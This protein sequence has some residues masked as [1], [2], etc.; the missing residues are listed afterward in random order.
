[1]AGLN[2]SSSVGEKKEGGGGISDSSLIVISSIFFLVVIGWGGMR[3]YI[4]TQNDTLAKLDVSLE[5]SSSQLRGDKVNRVAYFDARSGLIGE[6][7]K[8]ESVDAKKLLTQIEGLAVP[9]VRLTKYEYNATEKFVEVIGETDNFKYIAQ[10][11]IS[12]KS[13]DLFAEIKVSSLKR[14]E[15]GR[16]EFSLKAQF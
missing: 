11:I 10:Q 13:E 2:L 6:Q 16:I 9:Q 4:K 12:L 8:G 14:T 3:W 1:M 7:L 5:E 15:T